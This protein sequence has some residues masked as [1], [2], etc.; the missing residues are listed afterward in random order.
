LDITQIL[1]GLV[2]DPVTQRQALVALDTLLE[3]LGPAIIPYLPTLMERLLGLVSVIPTDLKGTAVGAIG[4]AA[5]ASKAK[6]DPYF[7]QTMQLISPFLSSPKT[8]GDET[9]L[10]GVA[11]DTVGTLAEAVGKE[12]FRPYFEPVMKLALDATALNLPSLRECS[13]LFF[14]VM[15]RVYEEEF[16]QFLATIVPVILASLSQSEIDGDVEVSLTC[17][18]ALF[19]CRFAV[20]GSVENCLPLPSQRFHCG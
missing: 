14:S 16:G 18:L 20:D 5:H 11:Q 4:S 2:N 1:F 6:F 19:F 8:E 15:A 13:F 9:A 17:K 12:R 10:R 3:Q 7:D